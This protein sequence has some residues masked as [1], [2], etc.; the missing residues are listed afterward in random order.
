MKKGHIVHFHNVYFTLKDSSAEKI[1]TLVKECQKY[2]SVQDGIV[3]FSCG[4]RET[5]LNREVNDTEFDVSLHILFETR[6]A[7][8]AY[9]NEEQH[10]IFIDRNQENW[11]QVRVFDTVTGE[12]GD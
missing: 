10:H 12:S 3:S 4:V 9:Q 5:G 11:A 1:D 7:H 6:V 8:D 2:L